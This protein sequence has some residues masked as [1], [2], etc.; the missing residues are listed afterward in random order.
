M[1]LKKIAADP[2]CTRGDISLAL[3]EPSGG[4]NPKPVAPATLRKVAIVKVSTN[5]PRKIT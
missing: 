3:A 4:Q 1:D 5:L 2:P